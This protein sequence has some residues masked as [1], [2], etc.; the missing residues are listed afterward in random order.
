MVMEKKYLLSA[1]FSLIISIGA[2]AQDGK[3]ASRSNDPIIEG[4]SVYPNPNN[5]GK[6]YIT[7]RSNQEKKVEIFD[8]LGKKVVDTTMGTKEL[9][10][11]NL[12]PGVYILKIKEGEAS[13]TR[14]LII[15]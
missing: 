5:I 11:S 15:N 1:L 6:V 10:I 4:L 2:F 13:A 9:N 12:T 3:F 14:K 8:V 7:S